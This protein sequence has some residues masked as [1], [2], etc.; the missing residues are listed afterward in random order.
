MIKDSANGYGL[1]SILLHWISALLVIGL[2][3]IG[4][5]MVDLSYYSPWYHRAPWWHISLGLLLFLLT[6]ARL[7]WR[8]INLQPR[9]LPNYTR[10]VRLGARLTKYLLYLLIAALVI[11]G[12]LITTADGK[13]ASL[14]DWVEFP[15]IWQLS[16]TGVD[17]AGKIHKWLAYGIILLASFHALAALAHHFVIRD[18]TLVRMLKPVTKSADSQP[19]P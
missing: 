16:P 11:T 17:L 18:R 14:F 2:F 8:A 10:A 12:Y 6:L 1:L 7:L 5:Y 4:Y 9:P 19:N 15:S 3:A 13:S